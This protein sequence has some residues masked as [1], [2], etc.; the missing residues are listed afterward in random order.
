MFNFE[1]DEWKPI[2]RVTIACWLI[3][4]LFFMFY[5]A[6][7]KTGFLLIDDAN[8][9]VHEGGHLLFSWLGGTASLWGGTILQWL[10]PALLATYFYFQR[11][12]AGFAFCA[13]IL[14]ENFLCT[15]TYMADARAQVLPLVTVG[16]PDG[17]GHDWFNIFSSLGLLQYDT[18]I[19]RV[20]RSLGWVG[21]LATVAWL[22]MRMRANAQGRVEYER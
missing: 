1:L 4:Y 14:F 22:G 16:N 11:H 9:I 13:F 12:P 8:L 7:S 5:A 20:V 21:M 15:A 10:V 19:A 2:S 6:T 3:F 17:A 18:A